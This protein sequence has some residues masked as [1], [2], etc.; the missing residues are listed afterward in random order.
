MLLVRRFALSDIP[1]DSEEDT[2]Q[3]LIK[4]YQEKVCTCSAVC[5]CG[6]TLAL[7]HP[8]TLLQCPA[9]LTHAQDE[10][11]EYY[12]KH[13]TFPPKYGVEVDIPQRPWARVV[14]AIWCLVLGVPIAALIVNLYLSSAWWT[15]LLMAFIFFLG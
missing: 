9:P 8:L 11:Y 5:A 10:I 13:K 2:K 14:V 12:L 3:W 15:L 7:P 1:T 4:L 6:C